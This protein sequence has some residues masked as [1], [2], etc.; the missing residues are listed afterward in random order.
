MRALEGISGVRMA[1][2]APAALEGLVSDNFFWAGYPEKFVGHRFSVPRA[3][4]PES[5][6]A[7]AGCKRMGKPVSDTFSG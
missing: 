7:G 1:R 2:G 5:R 4:A 6:Y 3:G